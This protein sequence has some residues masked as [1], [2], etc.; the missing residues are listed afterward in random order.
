MELVFLVLSAASSATAWAPAAESNKGAEIRSDLPNRSPAEVEGIIP[1]VPKRPLSV[2]EAQA[3]EAEKLF[4]VALAQLAR[5]E[6]A[7]ALA[8]LE[9]ASQLNPQSYPIHRE[10]ALLCLQLE[11]KGDALA[12][13]RAALE[14][15]R[16]DYE[17]LFAYGQMLSE[18]GK[19]DE[20]ITA[21]DQASKVPAL[22]KKDVGLFLEVRTQLAKLYEAKKDP[23]GVARCL[24]DVMAIVENPGGQELGELAAAQIERNKIR[25]YEWYGRALKDSGKTDQAIAVLR[26]GRD[27][28]SRGQRLAFPLAEVYAQTGDYPK[29]LAELE[30]FLRT[31]QPQDVA[32]LALYEQVLAKQ[33]REA[34]LIPRLEKLVAADVHNPVLRLFY[35]QKLLE[36]KQFD[37][38]KEQLEK[39]RD[40][41]EVLPILARLFREM[42]NPKDFVAALKPESLKPPQ[43]EQSIANLIAILGQ[44]KEFLRRVANAAKEQPRVPQQQFLSNMII[45]R[46]AAQAKEV[47]LAKE[48][49]LRVI[50]DWP[51]RGELDLELID[52]LW[53]AERFGEIVDYCQ[54]A[55]K[56]RPNDFGLAEN[57]ARALEMTNKTDE[58]VGV[59]KK[60]LDRLPERE[61]QVGVYLVLAWIYQHAKRWDQAVESCQR[62]LR[63]YPS[64]RQAPSA[65]YLLSSIY[66]LKGDNRAAE[67][68]L[69]KLVQGNPE[70][71]S[72]RIIA[73]ANNDLG[74]LWA[75][76]GRNL[77]R[78]EEMIRRAVSLQPNN[79]AYLDSL[80]WVLFKK[81]KYPEAV[82]YLKKAVELEESADPVLWEHLGDCYLQLDKETEARAAWE[83]AIEAYRK[84]PKEANAEKLPPLERKVKLL[85]ERGPSPVKRA[86]AREP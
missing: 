71:L 7:K 48:F 1:L 45:A 2:S 82:E 15:K 22:R 51:E 73:G 4:V 58:A 79:A 61:D 10:L 46:A 54:A 60:I 59:M 17:L 38:A 70:S 40:R 32:V 57:L 75:D 80:G 37:K 14:K 39:V 81:K 12:H 24:A 13:A 19:V 83:K 76:D 26:R 6:M 47:D 56:Q 86:D 11:R 63:D 36:K 29:A 30:T 9:R 68:E 72:P 35:G 31:A 69:L 34:E 33:K 44:D 5:K 41:P 43:D 25:Y 66:A 52:V 65:R 49:Y 18:A 23:A 74:Y 84:N 67:G 64:S 78:A 85:K 8:T 77:D 55:A 20:A 53:K 21:I 42:N 27:S 62:I 3:V 28:E 50:K 16:D